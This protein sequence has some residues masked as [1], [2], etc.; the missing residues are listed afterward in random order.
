MC[1]LNMSINTQN[2]KT[3]Y[4]N[5][6]EYID[7]YLNEYNKWPFSGEYLHKQSKIMQEL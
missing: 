4:L 2:M 1:S 7:V 6:P 5:K 3:D